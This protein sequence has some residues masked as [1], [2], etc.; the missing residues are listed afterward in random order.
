MGHTYFRFRENQDALGG[1]SS[2]HKDKGET[3]DSFF[4]NQLLLFC[5]KLEFMFRASNCD[6][7]PRTM[8]IHEDTIYL[9]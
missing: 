8:Q 7:T 6:E 5:K 9:C 2:N 1:R 4:K 3:I